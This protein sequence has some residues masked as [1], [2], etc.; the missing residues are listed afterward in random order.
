VENLQNKV[1]QL[2]DVLSLQLPAGTDYRDILI[3]AHSRLSAVAEETVEDMLT[4]QVNSPTSAKE[5]DA[6]LAEVSGLSR[7]I[8]GLA[9]PPKGKLAPP[10]AVAAAGPSNFAPRSSGIEAAAISP[11]YSSNGAGVAEEPPLIRSPSNSLAES[12]ADDSLNSK[13]AAAVA[14]CRLARCALS[15]VLLELDRVD[16]LIASRGIEGFQ[17]LMKTLRNACWAI[18]YPKMV[19]LPHGE[20]G[21]AIIL[22]HCERRKAVEIGN[23]LIQAINHLAPVGLSRSSRTASLSVGVATVAMPPKN[24]PSRDLFATASRCLYGSHASGGGVVKSLEI[25]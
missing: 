15:F 8:S 10:A 4:A 9:S 19:C 7:A 18:G 13:L 12:E 5:E 2:A 1:E 20:A 17:L 6:L 25:Y 11:L 24:F 23:E 3:A 16:D 22:P 14:A 21:F